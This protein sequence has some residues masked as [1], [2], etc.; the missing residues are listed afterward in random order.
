MHSFAERETP[1]RP[2]ARRPGTT[3]L[4][5]ALV[6][7]RAVAGLLWFLGFSLAWPELRSELDLEGISA[8]I[9]YWIVA[10]FSALS[11]LVLAL[12][13]WRIWWGGNF[14]RVVAMSVLT[15]SI[16]TAAIGYFALGEQITIRT[17][18]L[19]LA[20]DIL[21]LLALSSRDARAWARRPR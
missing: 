21:V 3:A 1:A 6:L 8:E 7:G 13:A 18:L 11:S 4:G 15:L 20:L 14:A 17:T 9:F 2:D 12:F 19:T 5:A 16:A 10:T